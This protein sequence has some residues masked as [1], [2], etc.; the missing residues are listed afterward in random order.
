MDYRTAPLTAIL[1]SIF[2]SL[3]NE[4]N[5]YEE[6]GDLRAAYFYGKR[7]ADDPSIVEEVCLLQSIFSFLVL[8]SASTCPP[9][10]TAGHLCHRREINVCLPGKAQ[11]CPQIIKFYHRHLF[12][13]WL[14]VF[15]GIFS[16]TAFYQINHIPTAS[17]PA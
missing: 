4:A 16:S 15:G 9:K 5:K 17:H 14:C 13:L 3:P 7:A 2:P 1:D 8:T 10:K 6:T 12:A 11:F